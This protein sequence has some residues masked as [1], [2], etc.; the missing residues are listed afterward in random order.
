MSWEHSWPR[1][2][3]LAEPCASGTHDF[4]VR[5]LL[6]PEERGVEGDAPSQVDG[7]QEASQGPELASE[8][9]PS[10]SAGTR[11]AGRDGTTGIAKQNLPGHLTFQP[12]LRPS[13]A[14][15]QEQRPHAQSRE[16]HTRQ[17]REALRCPE[18]GDG[19]QVPKEAAVV[20]GMIM[21]PKQ[22]RVVTNAKRRHGSDAQQ[23]SSS[24]ASAST[25][26]SSTQEASTVGTTITRFTRWLWPGVDSIHE[27]S[28]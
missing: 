6:L 1:T 10:I 16:A 9:I 27:S 21:T 11:E 23:N 13:S 14:L 26:T 12:F 5:L 20:P 4:L 19:E 24:T 2:C 7:D 18:A 3:V 22:Q 8:A 25:T 15:L 17:T 28:V